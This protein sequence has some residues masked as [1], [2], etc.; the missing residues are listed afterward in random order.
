MAKLRGRK[1]SQGGSLTAA[2]QV[3]EES[4]LRCTQPRVKLLKSLIA[5]H[6]PFSVEELS[7]LS[8]SPRLDR[9]TV[10]RCLTAF[11]EIGLVRRCEFGDGISRYEFSM[12]DHHHHHVVCRKCRKT[13]TLDQCFPRALLTQVESLGFSDISHT[14]EFFGVCKSCRPESRHV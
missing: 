11:E 14:L 13:Q 10:Y 2:L 7:R 5:E 6:G 12:G 9:V 3:L 4:G 1:G 8:G